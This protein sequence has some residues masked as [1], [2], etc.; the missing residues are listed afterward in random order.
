KGTLNIPLNKSFS[1]WAGW[2]VKYDADIQLIAADEAVVARAVRGLAMLGL[3]RVAA[4]YPTTLVADWKAAGRPMN[5]VSHIDAEALTPRVASGEVAVLDVRNRSE[6][7]A[8]H[9]PGAMHIPV[10]YLPERLAEIPRDRP[11]VVQCQS[12]ARSAI[13]TSV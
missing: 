5:T 2:L 4:W 11:L 1:T 6:F 3:D 13:A 7:E 10:G 9:L 12:G 8:G